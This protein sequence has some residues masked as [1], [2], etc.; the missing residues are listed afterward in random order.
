MDNMDPKPLSKWSIGL[1]FLGA[2]LYVIALVVL[3][4]GGHKLLLGRFDHKDLYF[5]GSGLLYIAIWLK[6]GAIYHKGS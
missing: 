4:Q 3:W 1:G 5:A 2:I 6:L